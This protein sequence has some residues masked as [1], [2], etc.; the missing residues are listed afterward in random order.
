MVA[1]GPDLEKKVSKFF[2]SGLKKVKVQGGL[3]CGPAKHMRRP[4]GVVVLKSI[5]QFYFHTIGNL[6]LHILEKKNIILSKDFPFKSAYP[7]QNHDLGGQIPKFVVFGQKPEF[8]IS[9]ASLDRSSKIKMFR[10]R[11]TKAEGIK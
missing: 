8:A 7:W 6:I 9:S 10:T 4:E 5:S 11:E 2:F 1:L 3:S